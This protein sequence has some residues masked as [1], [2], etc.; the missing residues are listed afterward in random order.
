MTDFFFFFFSVMCNCL[1]FV[2]VFS[3]CLVMA[4]TRRLESLSS[5]KKFR[6]WKKWTK[7]CM[8]SPARCSPNQHKCTH[9]HKHT[10]WCFFFCLFVFLQNKSFWKTSCVWAYDSFWVI[11]GHVP[12]LIQVIFRLWT[13]KMLF[14]S[15]WHGW[16]CLWTQNVIRLPLDYT[17]YFQQ[18][19]L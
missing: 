9:T 3:R 10:L 2:C 18:L 15:H 1:F 4:R 11:L 16:I 6:L 17:C 7:I 12:R 13:F 8:I 14:N 19:L 5:K